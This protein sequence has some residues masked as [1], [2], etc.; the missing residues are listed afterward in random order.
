[1]ALCAQVLDYAKAY[2]LLP[3][4]ENPAD[5]KLVQRHLFKKRT[6]IGDD[7]HYAALSW[8]DVPEFVRA[9]RQ[10]QAGSTAAV[11]L[12]LVILTGSRSS[13][14]L[15]MR[16]A[17][18]VGDIWTIPAPRMKPRKEHR[19]PLSDRALAL[20][21]L[22]RQS[23]C[24]SPYVF[25]GYSQDP[26]TKQTMLDQLYK[27]GFKGQTTVHGFRSSFRDWCAEN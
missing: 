4:I 19:V 20:I 3:P 7:K 11:A 12:E 25:T 15:E 16:W 9:L 24:G 21:D 18:I 27:M 26:L 2:R 6:K 17:E 14:V 13:E 5:W 23:S 10:R 8:R 22:Q 1:L